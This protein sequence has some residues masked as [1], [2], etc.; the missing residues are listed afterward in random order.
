M[1]DRT[2]ATLQEAQNTANTKSTDGHRRV[3]DPGASQTFHTK[4]NEWNDGMTKMM[5]VGPEF[6]QWL[7]NYARRR[8]PGPGLLQVAPGS[9]TSRRAAP[10]GLLPFGV[11]ARVRPRSDQGHLPVSCPPA[12]STSG[13]VHP[14][15]SELRS[16]AAGCRCPRR[17]CS[18]GRAAGPAGPCAAR[19]PSRRTRCRSPRSTRRPRAAALPRACCTSASSAGASGPP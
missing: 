16:S 2:V 5:N 11:R 4:W 18:A 7:R 6:S 14:R 19:T 3:A 13:R 9:A 8:G 17:S 15:H 12:A 10:H 1:I